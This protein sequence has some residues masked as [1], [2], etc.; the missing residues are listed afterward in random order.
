MYGSIG[1]LDSVSF[2]QNPDQFNLLLDHWDESV[3]TFVPH[4]GRDISEMSKKIRSFYVGD[5][6]LSEDKHFANLTDMMSDVSFVYGTDATVKAW[7]TKNPVYYYSWEHMTTFS[8]ADLFLAKFNVLDSLK[9]GV[10]LATGTFQSKQLGVCHADDAALNLFN[11]APLDSFMPS[12]IPR[13]QEDVRFQKR[14]VDI[15]ANFATYRK[16]LPDRAQLDLDP[17]NY[18]SDLGSGRAAWNRVGPTS[19]YVRLKT[20]TVAHEKDP[21]LEARLD[22]WHKLMNQG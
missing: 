4:H 3:A 8:L 13:S 14:V 21:M 2:Y 7:S 11:V 9:F 6:T 12:L 22:F 16:P 5:D 1:L 18:V 19:S 20:D 10:G 15:W 17:P